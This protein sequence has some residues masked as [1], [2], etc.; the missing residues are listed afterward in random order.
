MEALVVL[1]VLGVLVTLGYPAWAGF[2]VRLSVAAASDALA[3]SHALGRQVAAQ[4][5]RLSRLHLD[6]VEDRFWVTI[7]TAAGWDTGRED[8]IGPVVHVRDEFDGVEIDGPARL[9]CFDPRGVATPRGDCD[10]PNTT[11]VLR[12]GRVAD[13]VTISRLGRLRRW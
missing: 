3:A 7:D 11:L 2:R 1:V 12:R 9:I 4:Y 8:T 10:L 6:P 5:G 13:T